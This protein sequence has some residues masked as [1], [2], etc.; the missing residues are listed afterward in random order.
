MEFLPLVSEFTG[1]LTG[2][3]LSRPEVIKRRAWCRSTNIFV[4]N[5]A[6]QILCHQRSMQKDR[7]PGVWLTHVGGHVGMDE[8]YE[9]NAQK[10]L[11]EEAGIVLP[12]QSLIPWR[13]TRIPISR[14]W[15]REFVTLCDLDEASLVPQPGEVERFRWM[16]VA[17]IMQ[18]AKESPTLW[19]AGTHDFLVEYNCLRAVLS[20]AHS[21]GVLPVPE[22]L[23]TW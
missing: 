17:E 9:S 2:E 1:E 21:F 5:H 16:S 20:A 6:G 15:T 7:L 18:A 11:A 12:V 19:Q 3:S 22:R 23:C 8:T 14:L 4:L 10:E 13:T